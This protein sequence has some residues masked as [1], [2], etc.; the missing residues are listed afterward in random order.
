MRTPAAWE[1]YD[2]RNDPH[3]MRNRYSDPEY[4]AVVDEL[5]AELKK[6]RA[7]LNETDKDYPDLQKIIQENWN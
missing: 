2:L 7:E 3:E 4:K 6:Q 5:K 1:L